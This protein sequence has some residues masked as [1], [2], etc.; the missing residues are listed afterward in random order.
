VYVLKTPSLRRIAWGLART[1]ITAV[2]PAWLMAE[3][4]RGWAAS[5][6]EREQHAL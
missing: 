5:G 2:G 1:A 4:R 3:A 6:D